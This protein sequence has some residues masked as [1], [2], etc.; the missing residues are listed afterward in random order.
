TSYSARSFDDGQ[1]TSLFGDE[2]T[3]LEP[4]RGGSV[5]LAYG[6][7]TQAV[8]FRMLR[9]EG[10]ITGLAAFG[11]PIFYHDLAEHFA[12]DE[13]GQVQS[14]WITFE[15]MRLAISKLVERAKREDAAA[16]IQK[17]VEDTLLTALRRILSHAPH[18]HLALSGGLFANVKLNRHL[19]E[20]LELDEIF[21]VPPMGDEGLSLGAG[22]A[23]LLQRDGL[24]EWLERRYRLDNL[25]WG[26]DY[27]GAIDAA[28]SA[29]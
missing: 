12:V 23:F 1:L 11:E 18:R 21:I 14:D 27:D 16:S 28:L 13:R 25:Y 19:A 6:I 4:Y 7:V 22:L 26:R 5:A 3:L 29:E 17:L 2:E 9:H 24:H 20:N 8:G 15:E 10:K